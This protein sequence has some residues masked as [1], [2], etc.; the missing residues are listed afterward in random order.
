MLI[1][2]STFT[3]V[4]CRVMSLDTF[5]EL[6]LYFV[7]KSSP[8]VLYVIHRLYFS[9][10]NN[11]LYSG[12][13]ILWRHQCGINASSPG[14]QTFTRQRR[15]AKHWRH[16][17]CLS[18]SKGITYCKTQGKE[19]IE[20]LVHRECVC[21]IFIRLIQSSMFSIWKQLVYFW[22]HKQ[23]SMKMKSRH[24]YLA[25]MYPLSRFCALSWFVTN[26]IMLYVTHVWHVFLCI[27][28]LVSL[29]WEK[30]KRKLYKKLWMEWRQ[31]ATLM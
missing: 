27:Q 7:E 22:I 25:V 20:I 11:F 30:S 5:N 23:N 31:M 29:T 16:G 10:T 17:D 9:H 26:I 4:C 19:L 12:T 13:G 18:V 6:V 14:S 8:T 28:R 3:A 24:L 15:R 21:F 1:S 2:N